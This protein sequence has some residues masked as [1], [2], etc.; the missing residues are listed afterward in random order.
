MR[1][2][3]FRG[4]TDNGPPPCSAK[5]PAGPRFPQK[6]IRARFSKRSPH[7]VPRAG[8]P[9]NASRPALLVSP[10]PMARTTEGI[11]IRGSIFAKVCADS[12]LRD[13][14]NCGRSTAPALPVECRAGVAPEKSPAPHPRLRRDQA[15]AR[16]HKESIRPL[17]LD[18]TART[19]PAVHAP[20]SPFN[21]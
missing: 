10:A 7:V 18:T 8:Q 19:R 11:P 21:P 13:S 15:R 14:E 2:A 4:H 17:S 12:L 5:S 3:F 20:R 9:D 1:C 6:C 16:D